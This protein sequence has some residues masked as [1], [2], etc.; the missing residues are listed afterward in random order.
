MLPRLFMPEPAP[1]QLASDRRLPFA[2]RS[3]LSALSRHRKCAGFAGLSGQPRYLALRNFPARDRALQPLGVRLRG[4]RHRPA[5]SPASLYRS[6]LDLACRDRVRPG[7]AQCPSCRI[8]SRIAAPQSGA[9]RACHRV[10]A[11]ANRPAA[12]HSRLPV[13]EALVDDDIARRDRKR[14]RHG[15][16]CRRGLGSQPPW[17]GDQQQRDDCPGE[18]RER[19]IS[20]ARIEN[21]PE[22]SLHRENG[23]RDQR[24][25]QRPRKPAVW[26]LRPAP[27][28]LGKGLAAWC[29]KPAPRRRRSGTS[30][31][32]PPMP[33]NAA[34]RRG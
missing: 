26:P 33:A 6:G 31:R 20:I 29:R 25:P 12:N 30:A 16:L 2:R 14:R 13:G 19:E 4:A 21:Q 7:A 10:S 5:Q 15:G 24:K 9:P 23:E 27:H 17:R 28:H 32:P 8:G 22:R 18:W 1:D 3:A 11:S 34:S